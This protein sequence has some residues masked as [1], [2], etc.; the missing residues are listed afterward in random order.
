VSVLN[1]ANNRENNFMGY[2]ISFASGGSPDITR[3]LL[4]AGLLAQAAGTRANAQ[5]TATGASDAGSQLPVIEADST[6]YLCPPT[7]PSKDPSPD[8]KPPINPNCVQVALVEA[9]EVKSIEHG[10]FPNGL[11]FFGLLIAVLVGFFLGRLAR[12]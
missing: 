5:G 9:R 3:L 1:G 7:K 10:G 6:L 2:Q 11:I 8:T 12:R 4:G